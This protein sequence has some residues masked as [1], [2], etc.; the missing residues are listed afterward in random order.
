VNA[1]PEF[2]KLIDSH[3]KAHHQCFLAEMFLG[4]DKSAYTLCFRSC[5]SHSAS[6]NRFACRYV[7]FAIADVKRIVSAGLLDESAIA[8]LN[9]EL[10][11]LQGLR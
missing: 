10:R 9:R 1:Y 7:N 6:P 8:Q 4:T 11:T 2:F 5:D 3:A